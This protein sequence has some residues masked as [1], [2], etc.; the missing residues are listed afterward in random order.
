[1]DSFNQKSFVQED[2]QGLHRIGSIFFEGAKPK[3]NKIK[4]I[5]KITRDVNNSRETSRFS[6]MSNYQYGR[7]NTQTM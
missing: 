2:S 3:L 4:S 6:A 7:V 1:M 5:S